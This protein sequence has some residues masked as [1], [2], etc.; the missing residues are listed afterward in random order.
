MGENLPLCICTLDTSA[1]FTKE[2]DKYYDYFLQKYNELRGV[3]ETKAPTI[4][5]ARD[6]QRESKK[7]APTHIS[8]QLALNEKLYAN[9]E[10]ALA[11][12]NAKLFQAN[13]SE[14]A[15][16]KRLDYEYF[17]EKY[18]DVEVQRAYDFLP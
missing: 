14:E 1:K 12:A 6:K 11:E 9:D 13:K 17:T 7:S 16:I 4:D 5:E 18:S 8:E 2:V 15:K 10:T 3:N